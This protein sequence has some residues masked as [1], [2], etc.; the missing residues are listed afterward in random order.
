MMKRE[1]RVSSFSFPPFV[2][3][4]TTGNM[5]VW[6]FQSPHFRTPLVKWNVS[7]KAFKSFISLLKSTQ[8]SIDISTKRACY[9]GSV[10][11]NK[12]NNN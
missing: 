9:L 10:H 3:G 8:N 2:G 4:P 1:R 12:F 7:P 5:V 6:T 11:K